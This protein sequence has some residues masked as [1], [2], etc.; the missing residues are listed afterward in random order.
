M[1]SI[2]ILIFNTIIA[3]N[4]IGQIVFE[5]GYLITEEGEKVD[6][7]IKNNDWNNNPRS[8][9]YRTT[10]K[11]KEQEGSLEFIKEFSVNGHFKFIKKE[12]DFEVSSDN[13][14]NLSSDKNPVFEKRTIFLKVLVE[15][16]VNLYRYKKKE[17]IRF[18][19]SLGDSEIK[20]LIFKK[21]LK[22]GKEASNI[23]YK[24]QI[25]N[26][27][28][29]EKIDKEAV[30]KLTYLEPRLEGF[31]LI[32]NNKFSSK[33][34]LLRSNVKRDKVFLK[35]TPGISYSNFSFVSGKK[36]YNYESNIEYRVGVEF[37]YI[38]P[39]NMNKWSVYIEPNF[40][41]SPV[42]KDTDPDVN[43]RDIGFKFITVPVG[44]KGKSYL[45]K[46]G[47][48]FYNVNYDMGEGTSFGSKFGNVKLS[49]GNNFGIGAGFEK[50]KISLECR[51]IGNTNVFRYY[52]NYYSNYTRLQFIL[53]YQLF[54]R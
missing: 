1:K 37:D 10:E 25:L 28:D 16:S 32:Y 5:K 45:K 17:A 47:I 7:F 22:N 54:K 46:G 33:G 13:I 6:C 26:E 41:Y 39:I 51:Y 36:T 2:L 34:T 35:L 3:F 14:R 49:A 18:F 20:P 9:V 38:L 21:Y 23:T 48:I 43:Y 29:P 15:G 8:F 42:R 53:G 4:A 24:Q 40:F 27:F 31:F 52:Q 12:V 11:G 50:K 19:Y 44:I 30:L